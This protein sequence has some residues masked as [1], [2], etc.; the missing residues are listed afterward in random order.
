MKPIGKHIDQFLQYGECM[1]GVSYLDIL[2]EETIE[3]VY[4]GGTEMSQIHKPL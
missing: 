2:G 3:K 1:E 4:I